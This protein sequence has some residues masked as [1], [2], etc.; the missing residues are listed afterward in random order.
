MPLRRAAESWHRPPHFGSSSGV[1]T[2]PLL[3]FLSFLTLSFFAFAVLVDQLKAS[4][5]SVGLNIHAPTTSDRIKMKRFMALLPPTLGS[6]HCLTF[7]QGGADTRKTK[8][9]AGVRLVS[10]FEYFDT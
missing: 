4:P 9:T 1:L 8:K 10:F 3:G 2:P 5:S 7:V 6:L